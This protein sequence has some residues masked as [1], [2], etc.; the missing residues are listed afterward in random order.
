MK[1]CVRVSGDLSDL[2]DFLRR[3]RQDFA[4]IIARPFRTAKD[5]CSGVSGGPK[6]FQEVSGDFR[7]VLGSLNGFQRG[8]LRS[9]RRFRFFRDLQRNPWGFQGRFREFKGVSAAFQGG[10]R[11]SQGRFRNFRSIPGGFQVVSR[12]L[13]GGLR[14][15]QGSC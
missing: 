14:E 9:Q 5:G 10:S 12:M 13:P 6:G 15:F 11:G 8:I 4:D 7:G 1:N 3:L 2:L